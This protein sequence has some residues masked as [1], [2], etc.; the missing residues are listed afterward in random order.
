MEYLI[1]RFTEEAPRRELYIQEVSSP[2]NV[3]IQGYVDRITLEGTLQTMHPC[4]FTRYSARPICD[5]RFALCCVGYDTQR[6]IVIYYAIQPYP[7]ESTPHDIITPASHTYTHADFKVAE[8]MPGEFECVTLEPG[9]TLPYRP[10]T[11]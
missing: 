6:G 11:A 7:I 1:P 10:K 9:F 4:Y 8:M 3:L 2:H 5:E